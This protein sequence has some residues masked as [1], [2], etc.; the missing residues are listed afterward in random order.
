MSGWQW[1]NHILSVRI[2]HRGLTFDSSR[3]LQ[4]RLCD[5]IVSL[6]DVSMFVNISSINIYLDA[7][8]KGKVN[9]AKWTLS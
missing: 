2:K 7:W 3:I 9:T 4:Q 8:K 5:H 1:L 6:E